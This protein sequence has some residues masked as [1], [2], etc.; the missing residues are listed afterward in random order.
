MKE[1]KTGYLE[2]VKEVESKELSFFYQEDGIDFFSPLLL[3]STSFLVFVCLLILSM[4]LTYVL[5]RRVKVVNRSGFYSGIY[6]PTGK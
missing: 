1:E 4:Y 3:T 5:C 6:N 2:W